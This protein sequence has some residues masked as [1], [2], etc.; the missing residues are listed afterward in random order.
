V[1]GCDEHDDW[2]G[3]SGGGGAARRGHG[4]RPDRDLPLYYVEMNLTLSV[5]EKTVE[6]A[7]EVYADARARTA[8]RSMA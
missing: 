7:R 5:D 4:V 1:R 6:R 2:K 8:G 3:S